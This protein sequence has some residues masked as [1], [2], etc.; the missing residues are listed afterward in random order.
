M[1]SSSTVPFF[2]SLS[3]TV[4]WVL[5]PPCY[6]RF[7]SQGS[8]SLPRDS[9]VWRNPGLG[10]PLLAM[11]G[12]AGIPAQSDILF[13]IFL[14]IFIPEVQPAPSPSLA[15]SSIPLSEQILISAKLS[16]CPLPSLSDT[17]MLVQA[18]ALSS[19]GSCSSLFTWSPSLSQTLLPERPSRT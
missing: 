8:P 6:R 5:V 16:G 17:S 15:P 11:R 7:G 2:N 14:N 9:P 3:C 4:R 19:P 18:T 1:T 13:N 10:G 12:Q